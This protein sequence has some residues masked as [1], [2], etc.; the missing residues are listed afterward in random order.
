MTL[1]SMGLAL[2]GFGVLIY[3]A[4]A[5]AGSLLRS[6][7]T[8]LRIGSALTFIASI[9]VFIAAALLGTGFVE[10]KLATVRSMLWSYY[11]VLIDSLS[12]VLLLVISLVSMAAAL[13]TPKYME[14]YSKLGRPGLFTSLM[15]LFIMSMVLIVIS[16]NVL[17]FLF[18]WEVMTFASYLLIVWEYDEEYVM[19]AGWKYFTSMHFLS[20]LPLIVAVTLTVAWGGTASLVV[21]RHTLT[22]LGPAVVATLYALYLI[23]FA[24]KAG[25]VPF[26]FWLPDAH[27]AAPSNVSALLSGVMIKVAVYGVLRFCCFMLPVNAVLGYVV[28][29]LG[30]L[31]LTIG[32]LYALKQTDAKRLLAYHSVGQMGYIWLGLGAGMVLLANGS[33]LGIIGI[34][35]GLYHLVNHAVFKGL[36]FLSAGSILYKAHTRD[37]NALGG[38]AK[39]MPAT[40]ILTL[41][42]ALSIAGVPP[43]NGFLSK[44]LIYESTFSSMNW[45]LV[46]YGIFA[47][48]ISA[49]T[50]ASFLKFYT[51]AFTGDLKVRVEGG[52]V[53]VSML[54]GMTMLAVFCVLWGV[55]PVTVVPL[56][57][58]ASG[59]VSP[60]V[61]F[62]PVA[63]TLLWVNVTTASFSPTLLLLFLGTVFLITLVLSIR[64]KGVG[65][66]PWDIGAGLTTTDKIHYKLI[67]AHYYRSFEEA[68]HS[69]YHAGSSL[70]RAA[71]AG[72][73]GVTRTL[74]TADAGISDA[75]YAA[76]RAT[77]LALV[78][79]I[80]A[81]MTVNLKVSD[82]LSRLASSCTKEVASLAGRA[83]EVYV[84]EVIV[85]PVVS[86][87]KEIA[88]VLGWSVLRT[89]LNT[90]LI[91]S[92]L[93]VLALSVAIMIF[94]AGLVAP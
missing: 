81:L 6:S 43:F 53:P 36:L 33:P 70:C 91:Y 75:L 68:I 89:D 73:L 94:V 31:S 71:Y 11:P 56:L 47:L 2:V 46:L 84:D 86:V 55:L 12:V 52:E 40:S 85:S 77:Y 30:T 65:A 27:P 37:L 93:Y 64:L 4:V 74:I 61:A 60:H 51:T 39:I 18:M 66:T 38:L 59:V 35:A 69:L 3:L 19:K 62:N 83:R 29:T 10:G 76:G 78:R 79:V 87:L 8:F 15:S 82:A 49:A 16:R 88:R 58:S 48:F 25:V 28:A 44:W 17:W 41:V 20:T 9:L 5:I 45:L 63:A 23:G 50:L 34:V 80:N 54:A 14:E 72:I 57:S 21:L 92:A 22:Q 67:A 26:H 42:A 13:Y 7:F 1:E 90:Y 32:T 24:S